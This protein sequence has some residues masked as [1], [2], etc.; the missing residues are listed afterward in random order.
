MHLV[1]CL[2]SYYCKP[3]SNHTEVPN[4]GVCLQAA[5]ASAS[6]VLLDSNYKPR[7]FPANVVEAM[8]TGIPL[9]LLQYCSVD[10]S[11]HDEYPY[12]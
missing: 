4:E 3:R 10:M 9:V 11:M 8:R 5:T 7:R 1:V 6:I 12:L 2:V